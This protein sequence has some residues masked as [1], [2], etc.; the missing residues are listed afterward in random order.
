MTISQTN[1]VPT[2]SFAVHPRS[3]PPEQVSVEVEAVF[4]FG[5]A[6]RD[7][8]G[9]EAHIAECVE[10]GIPTPT[11]VPALYPVMP[12][13]VTTEATIGVVG[14][15][16][17]AEAEYALVLAPGGRW[18]LTVASD[19]S[20]ALVEEASVA[21]AKNA[22]PDV[23]AGEAWWLD[24]I[25]GETDGLW[26]TLER[27]DREGDPPAQEG[28]LAEPLPP[29]TLID[30]LGR[31]LGAAPAPGT[32][33]LSGT[34]NGEPPLDVRHWRVTLADEDRGC[35]LVL[36]YVVEALPGEIGEPIGQTSA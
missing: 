2:L 8:A 13:R 34:I 21:R 1:P 12:D 23:L 3:G 16:T 27:V 29:R 36:E 20:D 6:A 26:L 14:E 31:R 10:R 15:T 32:V 25:E 22:A 9:I 19:H 7:T 4:N 18:L 17:Y 35:R 11:T 30:L 24:E 33:V 28:R 5:Y